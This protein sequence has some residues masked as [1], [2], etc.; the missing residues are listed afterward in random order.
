ML[1]K[2]IK[3]LKTVALIIVPHQAL[4]QET[5]PPPNNLTPEEI[6]AQKDLQNAN[7]IR[8]IFKEACVSMDEED[9][10]T[11]AN[12]ARQVAQV[13]GQSYVKDLSSQLTDAQRHD[14][15]QAC[16][17]QSLSVEQ[18]FENKPF[19]ESFNA[20]MDATFQCME[21]IAEQKDAVDINYMPLS[22]AYIENLLDQAYSG[23]ID[24][25]TWDLPTPPGTAL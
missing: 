25:N 24:F 1:N 2:F 13:I 9:M 21:T 17:V 10:I 23:R 8:L 16:V 15:V 14:V 20:N 6:A 4:S 3:A 7:I 19:A 11:C 22:R 18:L 5:A 12:A